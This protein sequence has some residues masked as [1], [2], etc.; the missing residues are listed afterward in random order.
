MKKKEFSTP[1]IHSVYCRFN[2]WCSTMVGES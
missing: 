1:S 2:T